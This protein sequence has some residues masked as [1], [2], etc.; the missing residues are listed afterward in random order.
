MT[1]WRTIGIIGGMGPAASADFLARLVAAVPAAS[2]AEHPRI[3]LESNPQVPDRNAA[4]AG[5]GPSPG[6]ALAAIARRLATAGAELLVMPCNAAHGWAP[7]IIAATPLPFV[8]LIDAAV[9]AAVATGARRVGLLAVGATL[10]ARL[11]HQRLEALGIRVL[12]PDAASQAEVAALVARVKAGDAGPQVRAGMAAL[13]AALAAQGAEAI[14]AACT[15]VPLV[16]GQADVPV[17]LIDATAALVA[18]TLLA[19]SPA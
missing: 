9:A 6:P 1:H 19:A 10:G 14:I 11:Y 7:D 3:L 18:A 4:Q 15:E 13:A 5:T 17:P 12:T 8:H 16:L 2:D